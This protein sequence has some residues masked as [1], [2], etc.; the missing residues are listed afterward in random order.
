MSFSE[1]YNVAYLFIFYFFYRF[2][3]FL[4]LTKDQLAPAALAPAALAL[5]VPPVAPPTSSPVSSPHM[6]SVSATQTEYVSFFSVS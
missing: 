3:R 1:Y 2:N 6:L 5:T 4:G